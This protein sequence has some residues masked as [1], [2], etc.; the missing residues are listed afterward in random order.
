[1]KGLPH[2]DF[3]TLNIVSFFLQIKNCC[4]QV[5]LLDFDDQKKQKVKFLPRL[6]YLKFEAS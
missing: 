2:S 3:V 1:M 4:V 6:F 5:H